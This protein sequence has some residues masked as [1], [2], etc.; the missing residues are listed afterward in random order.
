MPL[1]RGRGRAAQAIGPP[2]GPVPVTL[3]ARALRERLCGRL[4][5]DVR[6]ERRPDGAPMLL[7]YGR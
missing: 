1:P 4:C 5:E 6:A 3:D 2:T 7:P